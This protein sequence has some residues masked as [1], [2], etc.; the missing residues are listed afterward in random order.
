M[1]VI[2]WIDPTIGYSNNFTEL[3]E[4]RV[5]VCTWWSYGRPKVFCRKIR[6]WYSGP[7]C[8]IDFFIWISFSINGMYI[9]LNRVKHDLSL[10]LGEISGADRHHWPTPLKENSYFPKGKTRGK[11][12][13][14]EW[15]TKIFLCKINAAP[16]ERGSS[17]NRIRRYKA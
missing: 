16:E 15:F 9:S 12:D 3:L 6:Y 2:L 14:N 13:M 5:Y 1:F 4:L 7:W 11:Q 17:I 10:F 8:Q